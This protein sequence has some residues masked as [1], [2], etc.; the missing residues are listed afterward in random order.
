M[1]THTVYMPSVLVVQFEDERLA[2]LTPGNDELVASAAIYSPPDYW[3]ESECD[4]N[5]FNKTGDS[6]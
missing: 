6:P 5:P 2:D 4:D 3:W 1:S